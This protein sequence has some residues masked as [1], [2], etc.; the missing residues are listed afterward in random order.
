MSNYTTR[1]VTSDSD[2][3]SLITDDMFIDSVVVIDDDGDGCVDTLAVDNITPSG[4]VLCR[5]IEN[6]DERVTFGRAAF[7]QRLQASDN[8]TIVNTN[9]DEL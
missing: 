9:Y 7:Q 8:F 3:Q 1:E 4:R 5:D 2:Q 6:D